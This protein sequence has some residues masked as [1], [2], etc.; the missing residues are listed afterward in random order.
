[1][2]LKHIIISCITFIFASTLF[3]Q[4]YKDANLPIKERVDDLM[5]RMSLEDKIGQ[6]T[7][8]DL[9]ALNEQYEDI[10]LYKI[11]AILN[12]GNTNPGENKPK[13]W[14]MMCD[15]LQDMSKQTELQIPLLYGTDAIHGHSNM[16]QSTIFPHN[17]GLGC[18]R[19]SSLMVRIGQIT[20]KE[21]RAT[22][23]NWTYAP[24][25]TVPQD[26]HWG[27]F[28]EGYSEDPQIVAQMGA[29]LVVGLQGDTISNPNSVLACA[30]HFAGDGGTEKGIDRGNTLCSKEELYNTHIFPYRMSVNTDVGSVMASF[31]SWNYKPCHSNTHLLNDVLRKELGYNGFV[32]SDWEAIDLLPGDYYSDVVTAVNAGVDLIM[33]PIHYKRFISNLTIAV[34]KKN[35]SIDRINEAV[36]RILYTKFE[37]GLFENAYANKEALAS[38]GSAE[39]R[40]VAR[41]AVQKSMVI[42]KNNNALPIKGST[43]KILVAGKHANDIGLQCGG[44]SV[45]WQGKAG[46]ITSGTTI[47]DAMKKAYPGSS[48]TYTDNGDIDDNSV[49][50]ALVVIGEEPY[51][52]WFGD[53]KDLTID[54]QSVDLISNI[55]RR[56]I[57]IVCVLISGRPLILEPIIDK[58]DAIVAAWLPGTEADGVTDI[59]SG[60]VEAT[61][62]LSHVWPRYE[63]DIPLS[64]KDTISPALFAFGHGINLHEYSSEAPYLLSAALDSSK[65]AIILTYNTAIEGNV[66]ISDFTAFLNGKWPIGITS[67]SSLGI[68][69]PQ[70]KL[71]LSKKL[72]FGESLKLSYSGKSVKDKHGVSAPLFSNYEVYITGA[73]HPLSGELPG[74]IQAENYFNQK[75]IEKKECWDESGSFAVIFEHN[76]FAEYKLNVLYSGT[77]HL[78]LRYKTLSKCKIRIYQNNTLIREEEIKPNSKDKWKSVL[79]KKLP[80][81]KGVSNIRIETEDA[82]LV[83]NWFSFDLFR[84]IKNDE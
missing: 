8:I 60:N 78:N 64:Y 34:E 45:F 42:L 6:M 57:P 82:E 13:D 55:S 59:I 30:K 80:L 15:Q 26:E 48:I 33:V 68:R 46:D 56:G 51:A 2:N 17:I 14:V 54:Q 69:S 43:S 31:S 16:K 23:I 83:L 71:T 53:K 81:N 27:R 24:C 25:I 75:D 9:S 58:C 61:G 10:K 65:R 18:A 52:E 66:K 36:R 29:A 22:G 79:I 32:V 47:L 49:D 72:A 37:L 28:Y 21:S 84:K 5:A 7:L 20:A 73:Y 12:G 4:K 50:V 76:E 67:I 63:K 1:M 38:V 35:V 11:G 62:K 40:E 41:E 19:D 44:W 74:F 77:Y 3:A 39:H 70:L